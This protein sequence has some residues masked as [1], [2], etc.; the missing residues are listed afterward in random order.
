MI[1]KPIRMQPAQS[2]N[3]VS[4]LHRELVNNRLKASSP[5]ISLVQCMPMSDDEEENINT[6]KSSLKSKLSFKSK[7]FVANKNR[8]CSQDT[9]AH[10]DED[11]NSSVKSEDIT[12]PMCSF[13]NSVSK[14]NTSNSR[15]ADSKVVIAN[16]DE[17]LKNSSQIKF[18]TEL[19]KNWQ[20]GDCKFG[21]KC[22]FAHGL[23]ELTEKK[24]LPQNYKTK[25]CK[26]FHEEF[27]CPY[28]PRCQFIHLE[29]TDKSE[30]LKLHS[31]IYSLAGL[32]PARRA[33]NSRLSVFKQFAE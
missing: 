26:Q 17:N 12:S 10:S 28:G 22:M 29:E 25:V 13:K 20:N 33:N 3:V 16:P 7:P 2:E 11:C 31:A 5:V 24:H 9:K 30:E 1:S 4:S 23:K 18:K 27:Y 6:C 32:R 8:K 21:T 19:C 14:F 15:I